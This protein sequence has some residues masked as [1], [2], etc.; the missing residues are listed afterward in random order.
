MARRLSQ[1]PE[2]SPLDYDE[3]T[4]A[5]GEAAGALK[6]FARRGIRYILSENGGSGIVDMLYIRDDAEIAVVNG[7]LPRTRRRTFRVDHNIIMLR[8]QLSMDVVFQAD[9]HAP[10]E[11][12]RPELTLVCVPAGLQL[13][14]EIRPKARQQGIVALLRAD[15]F[16]QLYGL[17][18]ED[19]PTVLREA[20]Q[21]ERTAGRLVSLP[22]DPAVAK[23]VADTI[24]SELDGE[25]RALQFQGRLAELVAYALD[26]IKKCE[27]APPSSRRAQLRPRDADLAQLA[28]AR[29]G[30]DYRRPPL[31]D[32]LARE[33]GTNPN[34]LRTAFKDAYGITMAEYC[35]ERR[36]REAQQL[37]IEAKLTIAQI[38]ER[39]GYEHQS[40]FTAAFSSHLGMSPRQYRRHRAPVNLA[41]RLENVESL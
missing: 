24:Q 7:V 35:L 39:V 20:V 13:V 31:F 34:K 37:L 8:A 18:A 14:T 30:R 41:L 33:L 19:L 40:A 38:A 17:R 6:R 5:A 10:M 21:G 32:D 25:A 29:L 27:A 26:A 1:V 28:L 22:L 9:G 36:L 3:E 11:F 16:L 15:K 4:F 12:N 23:L 2:G